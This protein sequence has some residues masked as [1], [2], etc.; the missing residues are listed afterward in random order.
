MIKTY[1]PLFRR[2]PV[3]FILLFLLVS[4]SG[5]S[6][7]EAVT[8]RLGVALTPQELATFQ[9]ALTAL[10]EAH[11]EWTVVLEVT[12]QQGVIEKVNTQL[13]ANELPDVFRAQGL[14]VQQWIRQG[15]FLPLDSYL[16]ES[17]LNLDDFFPGPVEQFRWQGQLWGLPDTAAPDIVF[18]NKDM[19]DAAGLGYPTD[20][21]T[22]ETMRETAVLL[23]LDEN[24][25]NPT[26]PD[27]NPEQI[28]QWGWNGSLSHF[29]QRHMVRPFG[30]DFCQNDDCTLMTFT[31]PETVE[32]M[33]WWA[34]LT[35]EDYATLYDPYGGSQTGIPGDPFIAGKAAMGFNGFFAI[36]Q[37]NDAGN[38]NYDVVQP[39][40]GADGNRY[41]PLST[42]GYVIA[43]NSEHPEAAWALIEALTTA[44]FLSQ[45]WGQ[46]GH[47]I[48]AFRPA[49]ES[50]LNS[51]QPPANQG[52]ILAA[53]EYGEVFKPYTAS[54]FAAFGATGDLIIQAM[55]GDRP[56]GEIAAEIE[57]AANEALADD[58]E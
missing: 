43:A 57:Q 14:Q 56:V 39:F 50:I 52:A 6:Q 34:A 48:P 53:M 36:G 41:T 40:L 23:T 28:V 9:E 19:F 8:L 12:S 42:N 4:C 16:A 24:G 3:I 29:W 11:P 38:I 35:H 22:F 7:D 55:R 10:D 30:G 54:A 18:Y 47:S 15:A 44:E 1:R 17:D 26:D 21:W 20:D 2:L 58:R 46:P 13:A 49:A 51:G 5:T 25:R 33:E 31:A 37:L 27:F 32:A 45:T